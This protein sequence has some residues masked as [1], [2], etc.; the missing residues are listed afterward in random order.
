MKRIIEYVN[1][2]LLFIIFAIMLIEI[3]CRGIL[4]IPVSWTDELARS[5][6]IVL[7]FLGSSLALRDRSHITVDILTQIIPAGAKRIFRIVSSIMM[8]PFI[9][10]LVIGASEN[11]MRYW[12]SVIS[13]V[14]WLKIGHLYLSVAISGILMIFYLV[15][16]LYDD[17]KN[18][19]KTVKAEEV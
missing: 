14:G 5:V 4:S 18:T 3:A 15:L 7:V 10:T 11:V 13:T 12:T 2:A 1:A 9:V 6:Y 8:I 19:P 16:N 17:I